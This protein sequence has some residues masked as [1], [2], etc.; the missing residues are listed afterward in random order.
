MM[1]SNPVLAPNTFARDIRSD[2]RELD[3]VLLELTTFLE[4]N[5]VE[6]SVTYVAQL[7]VEELILNVIK[8][9]YRGETGRTI[10]LRLDVEPNQAVIEVEDDG[11]PFDP[12]TAPDPDFDGML[13]GQRI[14]GLGLHLVR[15]LTDSLEYE[16]VDD[17]NRVR[18]VIRP[19]PAS[20]S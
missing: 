11:A 7:A 19:L 10:A 14:G 16:R 12:R 15:S 1:E 13:L 20:I 5:G 8:H 4:S 2:P 9:A 3:R 18:V 6:A 17:R